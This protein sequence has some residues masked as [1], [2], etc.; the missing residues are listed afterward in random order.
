MI[1]SK[2]LPIRSIIP[3][4]A[5]VIMKPFWPFLLQSIGSAILW[6]VSLVGMSYLIIYFIPTAA[7]YIGL[8]TFLFVVVPQVASAWYMVRPMM[9]RYEARMGRAT[10]NLSQIANSFSAIKSEM[11]AIGWQFAT[12]GG[13]FANI[14]HEMKE[15]VQKVV[16]TNDENQ[17]PVPA[18]PVQAVVSP[19]VETIPVVIQPVVSPQMPVEQQVVVVEQAPVVVPTVPL[20]LSPVIQPSEPSSVSGT[21]DNA[22]STEVQSWW[23]V[24]I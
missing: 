11:S 19:V 13:Q 24:S 6:I 18:E 23:T 3:L 16:L 5:G 12:M 22:S 8:L 9:K 7:N 14:G 2:F 15:I 4:V 17:V 21:T 10:E 1:V 20:E